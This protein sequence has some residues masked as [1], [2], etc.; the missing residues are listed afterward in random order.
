MP[1]LNTWSMLDNSPI[2]EEDRAAAAWRRIMDKPTV[3]EI[4]DI[5]EQT[6]RI[7]YDDTAIEEDNAFGSSRTA[8]MQRGVLFGVRGHPVIEDTILRRQDRFGVENQG[9]TV[10]Y[11]IVSVIYTIGE[12]QAVFEA[13]S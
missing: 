4:R 12:I 1:N 8:G 5:G 9:R 3:I 10:T 7:E 13:R 2:R 11:E 6:V